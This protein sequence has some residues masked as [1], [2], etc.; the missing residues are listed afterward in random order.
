MKSIFTGVAVAMLAIPASANSWIGQLDNGIR[1][2][3]VAPNEN[4]E[5]LVMCDAGINAPITSVN[6]MIDGAV[7]EPKTVV[8]LQFNNAE[9][10]FVMLDAE[11]GI[12]SATASDA[13]KFRE[14][15]GLLKEKKN[16]RVRLYN[17]I[18]HKFALTGSTKAIGDCQADYDRTQLAFN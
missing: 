9:P 1:L 7:P 17:G 4:T 16:V 18:Q 5:I 2:A 6:F 14:V 11:G 10:M 12:G 15:V 3:K 13:E 8:R